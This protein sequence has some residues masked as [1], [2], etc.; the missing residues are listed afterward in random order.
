MKSKL[1]FRND[2]TVL[3]INPGLAEE[4]GLNE[5]IMLLQIDFWLQISD[6]IRD[7]QYWTYQSI[8]DMQQKAFSFWS[9]ATINRTLKSLENQKIITIHNYNTKKYDKTR[10]IA[11][12]YEKIQ[13]IASVKVGGYETRSAQNET[14]SAQN[15]T[16]IPEITTEIT[17]TNIRNSNKDMFSSVKD[18][19]TEPLKP[20]IP[21]VKDLSKV[22]EIKTPSTTPKIYPDLRTGQW[23]GVTD[24]VMKVW[25]RAYPAVNIRQELNKMIAWLLANPKKAPRKLYFKFATDW[26]SRTQ[27]RG[28][29][30]NWNSA[31]DKTRGKNGNSDTGYTEE[32]FGKF[33]GLS[34]IAE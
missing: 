31:R 27:D 2:L 6:N 29:T 21:Q 15:E 7:G 19:A 28:G 24:E 33:E 4:I 17:S 9:I 23:A 16:T 1:F 13:E 25:E 10:W 5:S 14:R 32:D 11:L 8:R 30:R 18:N 12:N 34:R 3:K 20:E 26:L 22:Q